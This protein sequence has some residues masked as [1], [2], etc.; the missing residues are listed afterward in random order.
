[1]SRPV[2]RERAEY[3]SSGN[4]YHIRKRRSAFSTSHSGNKLPK[5]TYISDPDAAKKKAGL[6]QLVS[7]ISE[8]KKALKIAALA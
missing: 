1:M 5:L 7:P 8:S 2:L 4:H 3:R 6:I